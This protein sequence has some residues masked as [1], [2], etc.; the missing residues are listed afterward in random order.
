MRELKFRAWDLLD[1]KMISLAYFQQIPSNWK[2]VWVLMQFTGLLDKNGR[3]I[4]EGDILCTFNTDPQWDIWDKEDYGYTVVKWD[5]ESD[6]WVGSK[7]TWD[8]FDESVYGIQFCEVVGNVHENPEILK[9][10]RE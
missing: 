6:S 4:Y 3:E 9:E 5:D 7:W 1:K 2:E 10:G 8:K